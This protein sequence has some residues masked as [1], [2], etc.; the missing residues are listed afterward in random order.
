MLEYLI[1]YKRAENEYSLLC[2]RVTDHSD[3]AVD[4]GKTGYCWLISAVN[5]ILN[6]CGRA[7][8]LFNVNYQ[9]LIYWDK[10]ERCINFICELKEAM[11]IHPGEAKELIRNSKLADEGQ[12]HMAANVIHKHGIYIV[13]N[14]QSIADINTVELNAVLNYGIK[15]AA[16]NWIKNGICDFQNFADKLIKEIDWVLKQYLP[17][18]FCSEKEI[19]C[20]WNPENYISIISSSSNVFDY[21]SGYQI[22]TETNMRNGLSGIHFNVPESE[23]YNSV[24]KQLKKQKSVWITCDAGKFLLWNKGVFDDKL[25]KLQNIFGGIDNL[26]RDDIKASASANMCHAMLIVDDI[27]DYFLVKNTRGSEFGKNGYG[28]MS[29]SWFEKFVFQAVVSK[30]CIEDLL[31]G[32]KVYDISAERFYGNV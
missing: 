4:Q 2:S 17:G 28:I 10:F 1:D 8:E 20:D 19:I 11:G 24:R 6:E 22:V 21:Q 31:I 13:N 3:F 9:Q 7:H 15:G 30:E 14:V 5:M 29:R 27:D 16:I 32:S 23:F 12:W 18:A 26:D 25:F